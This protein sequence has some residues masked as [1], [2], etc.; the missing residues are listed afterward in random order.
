MTAVGRRV[1]YLADRAKA[2]DLP[3]VW[4]MARLMGRKSR[5]PAIVVFVDMLWASVRYET[6]FQDYQDW[7]FYLLTSAERATFITHPKSNHIAVRYNDRAHRQH[8]ADKA[9][10][11]TAFGDMIGREWLDLR[12]ADDDEVRA[13]LRRHPVAILKPADSLGGHDVEKVVTDENTDVARFAADARK[14]RQFMLEDFLTQHA[15]LSRLNPS[16]VNTLRLVTFLKDGHAH[17]LARVLK[18]GNGGDVDN[19]SDGGMYTMVDEDGRA[20][21]PAFDGADDVF[22]VHPGSGVTIPGFSVPLFAEAVELVSNAAQ[23]IPEIPYVG[24]DVAITPDAPVLIEGNYNTGVFQAK[25]SAS[26]LR[27]GLLPRYREV[28]GEF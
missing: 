27:T 20:L 19:F 22:E 14:K 18:I 28:I 21:Y 5:K 16:S 6:G 24:W 9:G 11:N 25:P 26:G 2:I 15:E 8:F 13:F 23:R 1:R 17:V 4:G 3:R 12:V 7:D 10:F